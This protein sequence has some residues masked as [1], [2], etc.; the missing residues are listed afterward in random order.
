M[1]DVSN[2]VGSLAVDDVAHSIQVALTP[3]FLLS[4]IGTL[5]NV[6]NQRLARVSDHT[7]HV[8][9]LLAADPSGEDAHRH[10]A[11]LVRLARRTLALDASILLAAVGGACTCSAAF[12]LFLVSTRE[13]QGNWVLTAL[14][15]GALVCIVGALGAFLVDSLLAW[16][17]LRRDGAMP[18]VSTPT[19]RDR[20]GGQ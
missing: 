4:G 13:D 11:H 14:F 19:A 1:A 17:G 9:S 20:Q 2:L 3:V 15:G 10:V 5:L 7:E 18:H 6:F 8:A 12:A 16:H